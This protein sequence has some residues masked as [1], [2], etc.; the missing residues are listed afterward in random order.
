MI[1][2]W[3]PG[4]IVQ[5][6]RTNDRA[7]ERAILAIYRR[8]T[9]DEQVISHTRHSNNVGFSAAHASKG[10]YYARWIM[11]GRSL[12]GHHLNKARTMAIMYRRQLADEAQKRTEK[13]SKEV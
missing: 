4:Q 2:N 12:T 6:L 10:S 7:V 11:S 1:R 13:L 5:L 9:Q 8:Q 3:T